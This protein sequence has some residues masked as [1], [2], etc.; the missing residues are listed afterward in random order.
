M[1][2]DSDALRIPATAYAQTLW[3]IMSERLLGDSNEKKDD[4]IDDF[5]NF[6][7]TGD[8]CRVESRV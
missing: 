7:R 2:W 5:N 3:A 4:T 8:N 1:S 6:H